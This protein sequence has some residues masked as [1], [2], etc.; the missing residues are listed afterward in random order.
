MKSRANLLLGIAFASLASAAF[1]EP[2]LS[3]YGGYQSVGR[4]SVSVTD[5]TQFNTDWEGKPFTMPPYWGVRGTWWLDDL[6]DGN[7][8]VAIDFSHTKAYASAK[9][10]SNKKLGWS[11]FEFS[12]GLNL[13]TANVFYR[14]R[15]PQH[16][17]TPYIGVGIGADIPH[18]EVDRKSGSTRNYQLGGVSGQLTVGFD[19]KLTEHFSAFSEYK[20]NYSHVDVDIDSGDRLTTNLMTHAINAGITYHF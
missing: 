17:W 10:L 3:I 16:N 5:G 8:G 6:Q 14:F 20:L 9:T 15:D 1:A 4:S 11:H 7:I 13:A 2:A 18:V 12:D 19:Y